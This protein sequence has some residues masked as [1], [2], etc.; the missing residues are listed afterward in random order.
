[1]YGLAKAVIQP[2]PKD[3]KYEDSRSISWREKH[4]PKKA[5]GRPG[6]DQHIAPAEYPKHGPK[7]TKET[8]YMVT[9]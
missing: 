2:P 6:I 8:T 4:A 3:A 1:M 9:C 7:P 5:S